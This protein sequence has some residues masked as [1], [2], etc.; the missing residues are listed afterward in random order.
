MS[1]ENFKSYLLFNSC[2]IMIRLKIKNLLQNRIL[3][4]TNQQ[5]RLMDYITPEYVCYQVLS[6]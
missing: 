6:N 2:F 4:M 5:N 1:V 3:M